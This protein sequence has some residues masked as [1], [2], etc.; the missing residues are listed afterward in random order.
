MLSLSLSLFYSGGF[1]V[2]R[3]ESRGLREREEVGVRD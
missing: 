2:E 1:E 3:E